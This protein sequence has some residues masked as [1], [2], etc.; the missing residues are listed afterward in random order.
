MN[1]EVRSLV[2]ALSDTPKVGDLIAVH[3]FDFE[4]GVGMNYEEPYDTT[5]LPKLVDIGK[6]TEINDNTVTYETAVFSAKYEKKYALL[7]I[8]T[9]VSLVKKEI[10]VS[11][12]SDLFVTTILTASDKE[13]PIINII[14]SMHRHIGVIHNLKTCLNLLGYVVTSPCE[15]SCA[16][17]NYSVTENM[18]SAGHNCDLEISDNVIHN[19]HEREDIQILNSSVT[20]AIANDTGKLFG[21]DTMRE[22][23]VAA[24]NKIPL[25][26]LC[27]P[28]WKPVAFTHVLPE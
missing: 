11:L 19:L 7:N 25:V 8:K 1:E 12:D 22:V 5:R 3:R 10:D 4:E 13:M 24:E 21:D 17:Y 6:V 18:L 14:G 20:I 9:L 26:T 23:R 27:V 2:Q 16:L 15:V 28:D